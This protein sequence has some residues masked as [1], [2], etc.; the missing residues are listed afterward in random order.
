MRC[1][2]NNVLT[3]TYTIAQKLRH[4]E[5]ESRV[6]TI[7]RDLLNMLEWTGVVANLC[8]ESVEMNWNDFLLP[9]EYFS[10]LD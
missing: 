9:C 7:G 1:K 3:D 4:R 2:S 10:D 6:R 5:R 8:H